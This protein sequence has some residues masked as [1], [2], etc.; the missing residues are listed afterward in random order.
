MR[1]A[2]E[3]LTSAISRAD[4]A[5]G[6]TL[7]KGVPD[8]EREVYSAVVGVMMR[9]VFLLSA[10]ERRLFPVDDSFYLE[11]YAVT[12]LREQLQE[13]ASRD[14]EG[15]LSGSFRANCSM[16]RRVTDG[17]RRASPAAAANTAAIRS[18]RGASLR[19]NPLAPARN[20]SYT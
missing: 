3:L 13:E 14:G 12:S 19:R 7:L 4:Q 20:A 8:A 15:A 9:L 10:E 17:A 2:V 6:G 5:A 1:A 18:W 11:S 16:R